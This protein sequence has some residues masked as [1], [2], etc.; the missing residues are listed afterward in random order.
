[1]SKKD[2]AEEKKEK[3]KSRGAK[4]DFEALKIILE[5]HPNLRSRVLHKL[6]EVREARNQDTTKS[7]KINRRDLEDLTRASNRQ[8]K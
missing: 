1:M 2:S 5:D 6:R 7:V 3:Y 8:K 4:D